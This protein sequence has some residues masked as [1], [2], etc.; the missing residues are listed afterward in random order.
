M[1]TFH[2]Q[3]LSFTYPGQSRQALEGLSLDVE[4]GAFLVLC[5]QSGCGKTTLL[6]QLKPS[7]AP[8]GTRAG[9]ILFQGRELNS[10][11]RREES[12]GIGFVMQS[13]DN[14][15]VTDK[16]WHEL[17]FGLESLACPPR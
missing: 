10:L 14:Q 5:G 17:A 4:Q 12:Q 3:N 13:P 15:L 7:L 2:I 11:D 6:R 9:N 1:E 16:V 8:H